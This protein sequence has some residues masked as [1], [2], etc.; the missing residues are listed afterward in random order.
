M[1]E[2]RARW[3]YGYQDKIATERI[4]NLLREAIRGRDAAFE[5]FRL[6]DLDAGRV[7]DFVLVW[8]TSVEGHSIKWSGDAV[9]I[10]WGDLIGATGLLKE[11]ADGY[12]RLRSRWDDKNVS[13]R[14]QT[15]R[16]PSPEKHHAQ[17]ISTFSVAEF[18]AKHWQIGPTDR[19]C[20]DVA[21]AWNKIAESVN[22]T[23]S[24]LSE[25]VSSCRLS[26]GYPE[27]PNGVEDSLDGKHYRQQFDNLHKAIATWLTNN[28]DVDFIKRD[29]LLTAI[30]YRSN[31]SGLI[32][33]F[34]LPDI[35]YEKN[36]ASAERIKQAIVES[37]GG[38][39]AVVGAAGIGKSTLVQDVLT[40][41]GFP[42]FVPYYAFL[43]NTD[44]NRD[45]AE[46]LTFFQD[47]VERLDRFSP[48]RYGLGISDLAQ[49]RHALRHHMSKANERFVLQ[50]QKTILLVDGL[51]H[52][53]REVNLQNPVLH[54]LPPP[55]E[56]PNGFL[57]VLSAQPQAFNPGTIPTKVAS[58]VTQ[59]GRLV[60][61][62][63]LSR[64]EVHQLLS[65]INKRT[66][67]AERDDLFDSCLGNPLIMTYLIREFERTPE[68]TVR[69]AIEIAGHYTG[70]IDQYYQE[71]LALPLQNGTSRTLL[72][73]LCRAAPTIPVDW[74]HEWPEKDEVE[75]LYTRVLAPFLRVEDGNIQFIHDSLISFLK[76]ET[77]SK[78]PG[79]DAAAI[80]REFYSTLAS[81]CNGRPCSSPLGR[82]RILHLLRAEMR[83]ELL[84]L[85]SSQWVREGMEAFL[86]YALIHPLL[87]SGLNAG[88]IS[89]DFGH[90]LRLVLLD[91]ELD[92][93][94]SRTDAATLAE[95]FLKLEDTSLALSQV[96]AGGRL[97][98]KDDVGLA[99]AGSL[100]RYADQRNQAEMKSA[101]RTLY[102]QTKPISL[103]YHTDQIDLRLHHDHL[104]TLRTWSEA[105]PL[106]EDLAGI[107]G[108][109]RRLS[110]TDPDHP[111]E[112]S[113]PWIKASL[114]FRALTAAL[115][116][117]ISVA[118][119]RPFVDQIETLDLPRWRFPSLLKLAEAEPSAVPF[120]LLQTTHSECE[121]NDDIELAYAW[122]LANHG[123]R[124]EAEGIV[125]PLRHIRFEFYRDNHVWGFSD[126]TYTVRLR[127]LQELLA[128][129]EGVVPGIKDESDEAYAR[130]EV[131]ARE[132]G[133]FQAVASNQTTITQLRT[134]FRSLLL[135]HNRALQFPTFDWRNNHMVTTA[136]GA[137]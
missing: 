13:V 69:E 81:R 38:Y 72:G 113:D 77:R 3:G 131:A 64:V 22:L 119:C 34:P 4:L 37:P 96:R 78:L 50:G 115:E 8:K 62:S 58:A 24:A 47:V 80:E 74:L 106:F 26:L 49:G 86:P 28:P 110:F 127:Y 30:G 95:V 136:K 121:K 109:I 51:D 117:G 90:V 111:K 107:I 71:R 89:K 61:V 129:P 29:F 16:P 36:Q 52:V 102:L 9:P 43:P 35:P 46:A 87:V 83:I 19:D 101:A 105:A 7:D 79:H 128:I 76:S 45:R 65:R 55:D 1:G 60:Q 91:H 17:L 23:G 88:W 56:V 124:V 108:E 104:A 123:Y 20:D 98:V 31:R 99:F 14:L 126:V 116:A 68:T 137:I 10:N 53:S 11:L 130:I 18:L 39:I 66:T 5:G 41:L 40:S 73:L 57:I 44:G 93:R 118:V 92:Q 54:E 134:W 125:R 85:L 25:F 112:V 6:A 120:E 48:D 70:P 100:W 59:A 84:G 122:F 42:F 21:N 114:L 103:I 132:L 33:R 12:W 63:G 2:R 32:H 94:T 133:Y 82:A 67:G 97:L 135:F 75:N 15:N 27:P